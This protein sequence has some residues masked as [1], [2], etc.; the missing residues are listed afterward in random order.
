M[1][2]NG[3]YGSVRF[4][5]PPGW[6][7]IPPVTRG[8]MV[9][10]AVGYLATIFLSFPALKLSLE[11]SAVFPRGEVW[12]L[13]TYP[14]VNVGIVVVLFDLLLLWSFGSELEP[15]WG[16]RGY[17]LFL[18]LST[19]SAGVIGVASSLLFPSSGFGHAGGVAAPLTAAIVAW[20][21]LGPSLPANLFGILPMT[22][23][24]FALIAVVVVTFGEIEATRSLTRVAFVL[25][26][27][28][29]AWLWVRFV[30][31]RTV[32]LHFNAPRFLRRRRFRVVPDDRQ[33]RWYH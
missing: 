23:T 19:L 15:Q 20:M 9:L 31:R 13:L 7:R 2:P 25:G 3:A 14:V 24:G 12:R 8:T 30:G 26:G 11:P 21:L 4:A 28:P 22:R 5:G 18:I 29:T 10:A 32:C 17:A 16:S 27:I 1:R 6:R 33:K